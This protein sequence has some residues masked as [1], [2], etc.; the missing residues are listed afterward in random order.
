VIP[1]KGAGK[2]SRLPF[3]KLKS[4]D[5]HAQGKVGGGLPA[6]N[7]PSPPHV[8]FRH[9]AFCHHLFHKI[10]GEVDSAILLLGGVE[11]VVMELFPNIKVTGFHP[12]LK[13]TDVG[14]G[15]WKK[16]SGREDKRVETVFSKVP[17]NPDIILTLLDRKTWDN[18]SNSAWDNVASRNKLT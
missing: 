11:N 10:R 9:V 3:C 18:S 6:K 7:K 17:N 13:M 2:I 8:P 16:E 12:W 1:L 15:S 14:G 4:P 5:M